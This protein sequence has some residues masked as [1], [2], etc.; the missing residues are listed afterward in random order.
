MTAPA[1]AGQPRDGLGHA[2]SWLQPE[3]VKGLSLLVVL[4]VTLIAFSFA[5]PTT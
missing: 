2:S 1:V 4:I 5:V 3:R